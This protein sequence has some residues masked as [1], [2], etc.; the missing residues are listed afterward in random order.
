MGNCGL[1]T[2]SCCE[3]PST[4]DFEV[5]FSK[6]LNV[7]LPHRKKCIDDFTVGERFA[8][9]NC[10][11]GNYCYR[12]GI[13]NSRLAV[14]RELKLAFDYIR[15]LLMNVRM[16]GKYGPFGDAPVGKCNVFPV[17]ELCT[18][19]GEYFDILYFCKIYK[20]QNVL[21]FFRTTSECLRIIAS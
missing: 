16:L 12:S 17:H 8:R 14:N 9:M 15:E 2:V 19:T 10:I 18:K 1:F 5:L 7:I 4:R 6:L 3:Y 20:C 21:N 11:R 13:E